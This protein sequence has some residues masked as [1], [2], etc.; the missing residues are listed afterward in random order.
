MDANPDFPNLFVVDHPLIKHKLTIMRDKNTSSSKF[1]VLLKEIA[2]LLGYEVTRPLP[3]VMRTIETPVAPME[4]P[5]LAE[6]RLVIVGTLIALLSHWFCW[7]LLLLVGYTKGLAGSTSFADPATP[8]EA[9]PMAFGYALFSL[10]FLG[11][12]AVPIS[13]AIAIWLSKRS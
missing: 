12:T 11:W 2:L 3:T 5:F 4:A 13:I 9:V 8:L 10:A 1:R 7:Y 6:V